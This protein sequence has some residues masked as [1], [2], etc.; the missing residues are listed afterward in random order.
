M[1]YRIRI[2][3]IICS[4]GIISLLLNFNTPN[5]WNCRRTRSTPEEAATSQPTEDSLLDASL[6]AE[7]EITPHWSE[8]ESLYEKIASE[9]FHNNEDSA[10]SF[11]VNYMNHL[12][13]LGVRGNDVVIALANIGG[14][15]ATEI[16]NSI[17]VETAHLYASSMYKINQVFSSALSR[18]SSDNSLIKQYT[19]QLIVIKQGLET[20]ANQALAL[21]MGEPQSSSSIP[22]TIREASKAIASRTLQEISMIATLLNPENMTIGTDGRSIF[23][24]FEYN[25]EMFTVTVHQNESN[26]S[27]QA[28]INILIERENG[29]YIESA[30]DFAQ[31]H[32]LSWDTF[33]D[34]VKKKLTHH[35]SPEKA[36]TFSFR[37]DLDSI[38]GRP[39][40]ALDITSPY[41]CTMLALFGH[42]GEYHT[43]LFGVNSETEFIARIRE[44][45]S[46]FGL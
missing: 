27:Q 3:F 25:G 40:A 28:R 45:L 34:Y 1:R 35:V 18:N 36:A 19:Q 2:V 23:K 46:I 30:R 5:S 15:I 44:L 26:Q 11:F 29:G 42:T 20:L 13:E 16:I 43:P 32:G 6:V 10:K 7:L 8:I 41:I 14:Y 31:E 12:N 37:I 17:D 33:I 24:K 22:S 21:Y 38:Q 39:A 9:R 4:L